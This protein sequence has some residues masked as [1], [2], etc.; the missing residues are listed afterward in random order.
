MRSNYQILF[1]SES[2]YDRRMRYVSTI[3]WLF[4]IITA[5]SSGQISTSK[6]ANNGGDTWQCTGETGRWVC[7]RKGENQTPNSASKI[8]D[9]TATDEQLVSDRVE[10]L[11]LESSNADLMKEGDRPLLEELE[12]GRN[13]WVIQW[14]ALSSKVAADSFAIKNFPDKSIQIR[15]VPIKGPSKRLFAVIS[16][17][18]GSKREALEA[19]KKIARVNTEKPYIKEL[20]SFG[21][22]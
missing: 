4:P 18:Y 13:M 10:Q 7:E 2:H 15:V 9:E 3:V 22:L 20:S 21:N 12:A 6:Q 11:A 14:I 5:C 1:G 19:S 16:G 17:E 8:A